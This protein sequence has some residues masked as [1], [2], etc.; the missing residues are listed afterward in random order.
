ML[1]IIGLSSNAQWTAM[2]NG[3]PPGT[4]HSFATSGTNIF[5]GCIPFGVYLSTDDGNS[6]TWANT[7]LTNAVVWSLATD[8]T[9]A[10]DGAMSADDHM[11]AMVKACT[12]HPDMMVMDAMHMMN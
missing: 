6:W 4:I 7:G 1:A 8:G 11:A 2:T 5:A 3:L 9:M 10:T 12:A